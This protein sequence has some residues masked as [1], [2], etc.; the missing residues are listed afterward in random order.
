[1][2]TQLGP[3]FPNSAAVLRSCDLLWTLEKRTASQKADNPLF[4]IEKTVESHFGQRTGRVAVSSETACVGRE[5][6]RRVVGS[7]EADHVLIA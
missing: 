7:R 2:A 4:N 3:P 1:M 5:E 6:L